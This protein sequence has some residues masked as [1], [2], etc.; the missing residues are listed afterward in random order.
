MIEELIEDDSDKD[1]TTRRKIH[2]YHVD[3][4]YDYR[5][6]GRDYVGTSVNFGWAAVYGLRE[7]AETA[8][9]RYRPG[10][11][12]TVYYDP[13]HPGTAILEP[14]NRQGSFAPLVFSAIFAI[15][16]G[17]TAGVLHQGQ[18]STTK[19]GVPRD[20]PKHRPRSYANKSGQW[21]T[22]DAPSSK[23]DGLLTTSYWP[24]EL[25]GQRPVERRPHDCHR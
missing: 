8:A 6:N 16:G 9:S 4:R 12:V 18:G 10:E 7:Q 25:P 13:D 14:D 3:L 24:C 23:Y 22:A 17:S 11:P 5:V 20:K 19:V 1:S 15:A 2:R 21:Q